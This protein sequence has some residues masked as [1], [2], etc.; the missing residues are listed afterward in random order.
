MSLYKFVRGFFS[1]FLKVLCRVER[2][3]EENIQ[4]EGSYIFC[5]NHISNFDPILISTT[6]KREFHFLA[7]EELIKIPIA[8]AIIKRLNV[9]PIK[10]GAGDI[11]ALRKS[12]EALK[13]GKALVMFPEGTRSKDG[14]LKEG[15][16][17]VS[18]IAKKSM[19][20]VVPC[21][22]IGKLTIFGKS[23][24]VY[25]K[26]ID[27]TVYKDERDNKI[28]TSVIMNEIKSLIETNK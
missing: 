15:K 5:S 28:I 22:I 25:G 9:I 7:K 11:G 13:D 14:K 18:L 27:M 4:K 20:D 8:G 24:I 2:I 23:K 1:I 3:G 21:A 12:I 6:N 19:C 26:P 10:R 17:G 16:D